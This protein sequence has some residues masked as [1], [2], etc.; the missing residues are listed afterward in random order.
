MRNGESK[1]CKARLGAASGA[2]FVTDRNGSSISQLVLKATGVKVAN[3]YQCGK[4]TAGCPMARFMDVPPNQVMRLV[5]V[6]DE[7]AL[8]KVLAG[9]AIWS[10]AGCLTCTQRCPKKL[11]L[12]AVMDVLR[13]A[14][15]E[16]GCVAPRQKKVL[17]FHQAFLKTVEQTGRMSEFALVAGY[18]MASRDFFSDL[19]LA[20]RMLAKGKL[21]FTRHKIKNPKEVQR[22]FQ[23]CRRHS[24]P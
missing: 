18:K 1:G 3:C 24:S 7:Q 21:K 4:C 16:Q 14:S 12:A 20:P 9:T 13:Q 10:C 2:G 22:I 11:D 6:G 15:H 19:T 23:H 8:R 5:Q 17:A